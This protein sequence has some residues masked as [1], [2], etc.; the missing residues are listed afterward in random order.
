MA[1][2]YFKVDSVSLKLIN[3]QAYDLFRYSKKPTYNHMF[4][5]FLWEVNECVK[6]LNHYNFPG[7]GY[8]EK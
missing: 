7:E 2:T 1:I 3:K 4:L 5:K 6:R 8:S